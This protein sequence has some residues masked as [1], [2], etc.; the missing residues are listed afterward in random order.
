MLKG[1]KRLSFEANDFFIDRSRS[2]CEKIVAQ[3]FDDEY[4]CHSMEVYSQTVDVKGKNYKVLLLGK[5]CK[6]HDFKCFTSCI[7]YPE[8]PIPQ[9]ELKEETFK[10]IDGTACTL[11]DDKKVKLKNSVKNYFRE[12]KEYTPV[13]FFENALEG[14]NVYVLKVGEHYVCAYEVGDNIEIDCILN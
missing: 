3:K 4:I 14:A 12:E 7:W 11:T 1:W 13:K 10:A 9:P 6:T 5:H 2:L 8:G